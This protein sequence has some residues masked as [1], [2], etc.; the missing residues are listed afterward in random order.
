[1]TE[2]KD[3]ISAGAS[4]W[5]KITSVRQSIM[6]YF[7]YAIVHGEDVSNNYGNCS[8]TCGQ[9]LFKQQC[10]G[11]FSTVKQNWR[12]NRDDKRVNLP[13]TK[14]VFYVCINQSIAAADM[15]LN[16]MDVSVGVTCAQNTMSGAMRLV[17]ASALTLLAFV[18][19]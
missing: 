16:V 17:S 18:A 7:Y 6:D 9:G 13:D 14:D 19:I 1:M 12:Y 5:A 15:T 2:S 3:G 4:R 10:C 11:E 8:A